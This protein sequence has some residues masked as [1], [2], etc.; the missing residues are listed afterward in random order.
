MAS[1]KKSIIH[2]DFVALGKI[3]SQLRKPSPTIAVN[4][5]H[6]KCETLVRT[7]CHIMHGHDKVKTC[8]EQTPFEKQHSHVLNLSVFGDYATLGT[9]N[10]VASC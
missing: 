10:S 2:R 9:A 1:S 6:N 3:H 8:W 4:I 7:C 5:L